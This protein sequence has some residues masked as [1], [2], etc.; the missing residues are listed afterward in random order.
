MVPENDCTDFQ[1][2]KFPELTLAILKNI[3]TTSTGNIGDRFVQIA[4]LDNWQAVA[5]VQPY[6]R[7]RAIWAT[8]TEALQ[9][10]D[11]EMSN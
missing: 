2:R 3:D 1:G 5:G 6:T 4:Y 11:I 9:S 10:R 8:L 7:D